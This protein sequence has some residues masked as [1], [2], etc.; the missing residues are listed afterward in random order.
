MKKARGALCAPMW[1]VDSLLQV[2]GGDPV[3]TVDVIG[4]GLSGHDLFC[5]GEQLIKGKKGFFRRVVDLASGDLFAA[6]RHMPLSRFD[7]Q[8]VAIN[9]DLQLGVTQLKTVLQNETV[10]DKHPKGERVVVTDAVCYVFDLADHT[11]GDHY[12]F[13]A[14]WKFADVDIA[15]REVLVESGFNLFGEL[16]GLHDSF[17]FGG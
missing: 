2:F 6:H 12:T 9:L 13:S 11:S 3:L 15:I 1:L 10:M 7:G 4:S 8:A 5:L 17:P 14:N 16:D